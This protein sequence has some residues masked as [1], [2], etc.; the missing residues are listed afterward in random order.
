MYGVLWLN[1]LPPENILIFVQLCHKMACHLYICVTNTFNGLK[2]EK[3]FHK[4][5]QCPRKC[6]NWHQTIY[7]WNMRVQHIIFVRNMP[8]CARW[9]CIGGSLDNFYQHTPFFPQ[10]PDSFTYLW[11]SYFSLSIFIFCSLVNDLP[12]AL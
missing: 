1:N 4:C 11:Y 3:I 8:Y 2:F 7:V 6:V 10:S 12:D 9:A 5:L